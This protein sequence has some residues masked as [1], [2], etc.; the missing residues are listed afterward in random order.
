MQGDKCYG[1]TETYYDKNGNMLNSRSCYNGKADGTCEGYTNVNSQD[2]KYDNQNR[3]TAEILCGNY[4][5]ANSQAKC[6]DLKEGTYYYY[7]PN[8]TVTE[9]RCS[10][11]N[12]DGTC[13]VDYNSRLSM[14]YTH[15]ASGKPISGVGCQGYVGDSIDSTTG[16]CTKY[17]NLTAK[18]TY[19]DAGDVLK[20]EFCNNS[21][22]YTNKENTYNEDGTLASSKVCQGVWSNCSTLTTYYGYDEEGNQTMKW[23]TGVNNY[24]SNINDGRALSVL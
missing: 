1:A 6:S 8:G 9:F 5:T 16:K 23:T 18:F 10:I 4:S 12:S 3:L 7:N 11:L 13:R 15:D 20:E 14:T 24:I 2:F 17:Q 21:S 22:C 19:N